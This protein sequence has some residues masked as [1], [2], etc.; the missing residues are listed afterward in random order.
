[1]SFSNICASRSVNWMGYQWWRSFLFIF[2]N[3]IPVTENY[4]TEHIVTR[5]HIGTVLII[6]A[7]QCSQPHLIQPVRNIYRNNSTTNQSFSCVLTFGVFSTIY[8]SVSCHSL[9]FVPLSPCNFLFSLFIVHYRRT[10]YGPL[11]DSNDYGTL[12]NFSN[13]MYDPWIFKFP[14]NPK[15]WVCRQ[16]HSDQCV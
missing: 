11:L 5:F 14:L 4:Y 3:R 13:P 7:D 8:W 12:G 2:M 16:S 6:V 10:S 9:Y 15:S 1:M